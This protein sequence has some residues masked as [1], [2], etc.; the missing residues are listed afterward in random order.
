VR[1]T[2]GDSEWIGLIHTRMTCAGILL[3][4]RQTIGFKIYEEFLD[5][6]SF[7]EELVMRYFIALHTFNL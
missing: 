4:D 6:T 3:I 5:Q 2:Q 7:V 1:E